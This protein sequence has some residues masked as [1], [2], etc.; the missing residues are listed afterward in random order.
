MRLPWRCGDQEILFRC[1]INYASS[2]GAWGMGS[3]ESEPYVREALEL[4]RQM[5]ND[6][7]GLAE[8]KHLFA[9]FSTSANEYEKLLREALEVFQKELPAGHPKTVQ[10]D[11]SLGQALVSAG[12]FEE[13]E[14]T[15]RKALHG[16]HKT[17]APDHP[18]QSI[19]LRFLIR[20][21]IEQGKMKEAEAELCEHVETFPSNIN[22]YL[23]LARFRMQHG[24]LVGATE[25]L[26]GDLQAKLEKGEFSVPWAVS[27]LQVG[28]NE[29]FEEYRRKYLDVAFAQNDFK[30]KMETAKVFLL[31][32]GSAQEIERSS[33]FARLVI[34]NATDSDRYYY[35]DQLNALLDLQRN[36]IASAKSWASRHVARNEEWK[37]RLSEGWF[38]RALACARLQRPE[39]A[40]SSFAKGNELLAK[41]L[42]DGTEAYLY[43]GD[44]W[45][46]ARYLAAEAQRAI[47]AIPATITEDHEAKDADDLA[48]EAEARM[49]GLMHAKQLEEASGDL[50]RTMKLQPT[51][52][53]LAVAV[54]TLA[55]E[56][57]QRGETSKLGDLYQEIIEL[58]L[59]ADTNSLP[60]VV[61]SLNDVAGTLERAGK[62]PEAMLLLEQKL[63]L[64]LKLY[65]YD[66]RVVAD[67]IGWRAS[68]FAKNGQPAEAK[69]LLDKE[70]VPPAQQGEIYGRAGFWKEAIA[71]NSR[72]IESAPDTARPYLLLSP[73]LLL[74][75]DLDGYRR[76]CQQAV[77]RFSDTKDP[78]AADMVAKTCSLN[79]SPGVNLT[80]VS[81]AA[82]TAV[83]LG[84][85][86]EY[87]PWF[88]LCKSLAEYRQEHYASATNWAETALVAAGP[89]PERDAAAY[90]VSAMA[91][92]K[93]R[94]T[95][96]A[97][98]AFAKGAEIVEQKLPKLD[99]HDLGGQWVDVIIANLLLREARALSQS[100][101]P[102]ATDVR[103]VA[104]P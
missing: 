77:T 53:F 49:E 66:T 14:R 3:T 82:E 61:A 56:C 7:V 5:G 98:G 86:S 32:G 101:D 95:G 40:K 83:T 19:V 81:N 60:A 93:L 99:S 9:R 41:N 15:L 102:P 1:L 100:N 4:K 52:A 84:K 89:I 51:N 36:Q 6:P 39:S 18:Y 64:E 70:A 25:A 46:L 10:G 45:M 73:L 47:A 17:H 104:Q 90:L 79:P 54:F 62:Y 28:A 50:L 12:K 85:T 8:A 11:F 55:K 63:D 103:K 76:L 68:L 37:P 72:S 74:Q 33:Q 34:T 16:F 71:Q 24:S 94:Q 57:A 91:Q 29:K 35:L 65:G 38:I 43:M 69:A 20:A 22:Y 80:A 31:H 88:A 96:A 21:L 27:L 87:F 23:M 30:G 59:R 92:M 48:F 78:G 58:L 26:P 67:T 42:P 2:F 44:E 97:R 75:N 13:A